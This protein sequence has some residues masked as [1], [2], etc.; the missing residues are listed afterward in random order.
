MSRPTIGVAEDDRRPWRRWARGRRARRKLL[1]GGVAGLVGGDGVGDGVG[2]D[3]ANG[4]NGCAACGGGRIPAAKPIAFQA[5]TH[6]A[7]QILSP[8]RSGMS[9]V[10][11]LNQ[12][13]AD[14]HLKTGHKTESG[15]AARDNEADEPLERTKRKSRYERTRMSRERMSRENEADEPRE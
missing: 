7:Q 4:L 13:A 1:A 9:C 11:V 5:A 6:F 15:W 14:L 8:K 10:W 3:D 2:G 12:M